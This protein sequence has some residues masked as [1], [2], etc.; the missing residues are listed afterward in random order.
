MALWL[1]FTLSP[2]PWCHER[3]SQQRQAIDGTLCVRPEA[4]KKALLSRRESGGNESQ[5]EV[6]VKGDEDAGNKSRDAT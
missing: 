1:L 4:G 2:L 5:G 6:C 3:G